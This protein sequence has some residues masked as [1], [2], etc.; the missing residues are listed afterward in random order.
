MGQKTSPSQSTPSPPACHVP[1]ALWSFHGVIPSR[2]G[3]RFQR[4][5]HHTCYSLGSHNCE[6][7]NSYSHSL[8]SVYGDSVC[9]KPSE[10]GEGSGQATLVGQAPRMVHQ[11]PCK[12]QKPGTHCVPKMGQSQG[13]P[14]ISVLT[15]HRT[16]PAVLR[17]AD[18][19][20]FSQQ[21]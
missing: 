20:L 12:M 7:C 21:S 8:P 6:I 15:H 2:A 13:L 1:K 11:R 17:E 16:L 4:T 18:G 19:N 5:D 3:V 10:I 9:T 14:I